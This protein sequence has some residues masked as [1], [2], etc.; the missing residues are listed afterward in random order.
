MRAALI[1]MKELAQAKQRLSGVLDA[2]QRAE[3]ALAMLT[4]VVTAAI[5]SGSF[6]LVTVVSADSEV[7]W[8]A[9]ELG[10]RPIV[11]PATLRTRTGLQALNAGLTFAQ[12]YLARRVGISDLVIVPADVPLVSPGDLYGIV[13]ALGDDAPRAVIVSSADNGTNALAMRP[14]E[15]VPMHFGP[16]SAAAHV[17]AAH[18]A[19]VGVVTLAVEGLRF[20][21]D[22]EDDL[23]ALPSLPCGAA[24]RGWLDAHA[25][26]R[27]G[28]RTGGA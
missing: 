12:R 20:D 25:A 27:E 19:G 5:D 16:D 21:V 15:A 9:R 13:E 4:D 8:H 24:T 11:E 26:A 7:S 18:E 2:R 1:P 6:D 23:R 3:L 22:S 10:A 17:T 14:A 28:R